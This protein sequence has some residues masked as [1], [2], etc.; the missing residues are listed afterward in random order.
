MPTTH[1]V[2]TVVQISDL[3]IDSTE[4]VAG[5]ALDSR[6]TTQLAAQFSWGDGVLGR[7]GR[8]LQD[9]V[10]ACMRTK[11]PSRTASLLMT[12]LEEKLWE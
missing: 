11:K 6:P 4:S 1:R 2:R 7:D 8:A 10:E 5:D 12:N 3:H 9:V